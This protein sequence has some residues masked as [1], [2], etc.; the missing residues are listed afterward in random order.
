[1]TRMLSNAANPKS[2]AGRI[3]S[4]I[5]TVSLALMMWDAN[6]LNYAFAADGDEAA[7]TAQQ[8]NS[9][10][11]AEEEA[12]AKKAAAEKAAAEK[13][14]AEKAAAE[15]AA[16][17]KAAAEK[18]AAQ[19]EK[20][21]AAANEGSNDNAGSDDSGNEAS[22]ENQDPSGATEGDDKG[23]DGEGA[24]TDGN[25]EE[26]AAAGETEDPAADADAAA[27]D[28]AK[29]DDAEAKD[30]DKDE[31]AEYPAQ[32]FADNANGVNVKVTAPKGA[33]PEGTTM[34]V[35]AVT[36]S[37]T[38]NKIKDAATADEVVSVKAVDITFYDEKGKQIEPKEVVKVSL[39]SSI[40][41]DAED[42][43]TKSIDVVHVKDSGAT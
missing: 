28:E 6:A 40:I 38:I 39:K 12:A 35:E 9:A 14:A 10:K 32:T 36:D 3:I 34:K 1:M 26:G 18:E 11:Q 13:A 5:L 17:E 22:G 37:A 30:A 23:P 15:K 19:A 43:A 2:L 33:L 27:D 41:A 4:V 24:A 31:K 20:E 25:S 42:D 16:A 21:A 8:E 29:K 7:V